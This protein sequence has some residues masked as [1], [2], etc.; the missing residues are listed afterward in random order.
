MATGDVMR[1]RAVTV[2]PQD[3]VRLAVLRMLEEGVGSV[4]VCEQSHA[5][6]VAARDCGVAGVGR[7]RLRVSLFRY[8]DDFGCPGES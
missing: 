2:E 3:S 1:V 8:E 4:A 6:A 5:K 7:T